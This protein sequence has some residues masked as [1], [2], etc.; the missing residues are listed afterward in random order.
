V[1]HDGW[2]NAVTDLARFGAHT[3]LAFRRA[4]RHANYPY[5]DVFV[6]RSRDLERWDVCARIT[7]GFDDRDP[8]LLADGERLWLY[9]GSSRLEHETDGAP[10][11]KSPCRTDTYVS[12][13]LDGSAWEV[14]RRVCADDW[15]WRPARFAEG[16]FGAAYGLD[17]AP[18]P[19][20]RE[21]WLYRSD[22]GLA[23]QRVV[24]L[25]GEGRGNETALARTPDGRMLAVVRGA[26]DETLVLDAAAPFTSWRE[27]RLAH[28]AHAPALAWVGGRLVL[29]GRDRAESGDAV[30]RL[31]ALDLGD[32][33]VAQSEWLLDLPSGGDTSY[34]GLVVED[35][36]T[37]LVSYYSQHEFAGEPGFVAGNKPA[38]VYLARVVI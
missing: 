1:Y 16:Y 24:R 26:A 28:R 23:W 19:P 6:V 20:V 38:A 9:F 10:R 22:D 8:K 30:T 13:T 14:P 25:V 18:S 4:Q 12:S 34:C 29:A 31:W 36:G 15:L 2:H 5:G 32:P 33:D 3:Y 35:E 21:V 27:R 11:E 7:S 37:L 17:R